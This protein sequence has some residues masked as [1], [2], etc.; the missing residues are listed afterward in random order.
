MD[1]AITSG[2]KAEL[3]TKIVSGELVRFIGGIVGSQPEIWQTKVHRTEPLDANLMA[4]DVTINAKELG[5]ERS[6]TALLILAR[7]GNGWKLA[8]IDLFEVR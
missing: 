5:Q 1:L 7:T 2:K 4:V 8:D 3:E 6:G